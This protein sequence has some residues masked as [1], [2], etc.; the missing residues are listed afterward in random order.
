[1]SENI[2]NRAKFYTDKILYIFDGL[3]KC[4]NE[5]KRSSCTYHVKYKFNPDS[6]CFRT[7]RFKAFTVLAKRNEYKLVLVK[8]ENRLWIDDEGT[9]T[10][11]GYN[12]QF[13]KIDTYSEDV[14][15]MLSTLFDS[16]ELF[17]YYVA[18]LLYSAGFRGYLN[19]D[20][21]HNTLNA[22]MRHVDDMY[23]CREK[24]WR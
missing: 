10:M 11:P 12:R 23:R 2:F 16:T 13:M 14:D 18:S 9:N 1:M 21:S 15:F 6:F 17:D 8:D 3:D 5:L 22:L 19:K 7:D 24:L 4:K 20:I